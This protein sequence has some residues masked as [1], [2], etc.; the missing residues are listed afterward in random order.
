[1]AANIVINDLPLEMLLEILEYLNLHEAVDNASKTCQLWKEAV[2][3]H[4]LGPEVKKLACNNRK[5]K[6]DIMAKGW[7]E[8]TKDTDLILSLYQ[9]YEYW[10][11]KYIS[12]CSIFKKQQCEWTTSFGISSL[13]QSLLTTVLFWH[14]F[15]LLNPM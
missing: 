13:S 7:T 12:T 15:A 4:I 14:L 6:G 8:E 1:M 3:Q 9:D 5:F 11:S 10:S 2:A